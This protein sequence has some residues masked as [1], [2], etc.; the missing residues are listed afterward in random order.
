MANKL[1]LGFVA[2]ERFWVACRTQLNETGDAFLAD[3][4]V[5]HRIQVTFKKL[6][7]PLHG[8]VGRR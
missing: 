1:L 8:F 3:A 7:F 4:T 2:A 6:F 5:L